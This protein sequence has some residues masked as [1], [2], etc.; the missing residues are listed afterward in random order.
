[1]CLGPDRIVDLSLCEICA[2]PFE[3]IVKELQNIIISD[4]GVAFS[5]SLKAKYAVLT[6]Y[7][8]T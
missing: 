6:F 2:K 7:P 4:L 1:M 8:T 5:H 3:E